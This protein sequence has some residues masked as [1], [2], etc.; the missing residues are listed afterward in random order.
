MKRRQLTLFGLVAPSASG[1][2]CSSDLPRGPLF[3]LRVGM[4]S[5]MFRTPALGFAMLCAGCGG[6]S[7]SHTVSNV[8]LPDTWSAVCPGTYVSSVYSATGS[9]EASL[10]KSGTALTG[11][12]SV[13]AIDMTDSPLTGIAQGSSIVF[14]DI[15][16][17]IS[18]TGSFQGNSGGLTGAGTYTLPEDS[19]HGTWTVNCN[20]TTVNGAGGSSGLAGTIPIASGGSGM[21]GWASSGGTSA[22]GGLVT[23]GT[24]SS[25]DA[26]HTGGTST[27]TS[28][29]SSAPDPCGG[30]LTGT[31][32]IIQVCNEGDLS[33]S[34]ND[35]IV[36]TYSTTCSSTFRSVTESASGSVTYGS[37][38]MTTSVTLTV[39]ETL[40]LTPA[41]FSSI[42]GQT[43]TVNAAFCSTYA[44][45]M[46]AQSAGS[47]ANCAFDGANCSCAVTMAVS[48]N[49]GT[50]SISGTSIVW[51]DGTTS[52]YCVQGN[53]MVERDQMGT[54][55]SMVTTMTKQ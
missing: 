42:A 12:L 28:D 11:T 45:T 3:M 55:A 18:F 46:E 54:S 48:G 16:Q 29:C 52:T 33:Q 19:D 31:W 9:F 37:G 5:R 10:S 14:G 51:S 4:Q 27:A 2:A 22:T 6:S 44:S 1:I 39:S 20:F 8:L 21:G 41:C 23:G 26:G 13:P 50:Y 49:S 15:A 35:Q 25:G 53:T 34:F 32:K 24:T 17:R 30:D 38:T 40:L 36:Q 47:T 7:D 43:V